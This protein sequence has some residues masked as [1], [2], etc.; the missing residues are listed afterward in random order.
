VSAPV[1]PRQHSDDPRRIGAYSGGY[2]APEDIAQWDAKARAGDG[3]AAY[4]LRQVGYYDPQ[5]N[6]AYGDVGA[7]A[8]AR[9]LTEW[10]LGTPQPGATTA[11]PPS[12]AGG[13]RSPYAPIPGT[14]PVTGQATS[15]PPA[16]HQGGPTMADSG[17]G[18]NP[19]PLVG[20]GG[21]GTTT[22]VTG[23][24]PAYAG[25]STSRELLL[26]GDRASRQAALMNALL[27]GGSRYSP[28]GAFLN[29]TMPSL[30]ESFYDV[31][32]GGNMSGTGS[33]MDD[34]SAMIQRFANLMRGHGGLGQLQ[35]A[36]QTGLTGAS[37]WLA[38]ADPDVVTRFMNAVTGLG[39][40]GQP[41]LVAHARQNM[42]EDVLSNIYG[43]TAD[44]T[45]QGSLWAQ[46]QADPLSKQLGLTLP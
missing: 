31:G 5:N 25:N 9:N 12:T 22:P 35:A 21:G 7:W 42:L 28:F 14:N 2:Y 1:D 8:K 27:G 32:G 46:I 3:G 45:Q 16:Q 6:P 30:A 10:R 29:R 40:I 41:D 39:N 34:Y 24:T 4:V 15:P 26:R 36:A 33:P 20:G 38:R 18:Q 44:P 43:G 37:P 13:V 23:A 19:G 11:P 17:G